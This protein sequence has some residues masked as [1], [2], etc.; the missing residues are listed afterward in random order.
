MSRS[1]LS[2]P[3]IR[4]KHKAR[5]RCRKPSSTGF[6]LQLP[7]GYPDRD[8]GMQILRRYLGD[9]PL[10]NLDPVCHREEDVLAARRLIQTVSCPRIAT[11]I[12]YAAD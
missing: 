4:S 1:S 5:I 8:E 11:G 7:M 10:L 2:Q 9:N 12:H 3:R 6:F